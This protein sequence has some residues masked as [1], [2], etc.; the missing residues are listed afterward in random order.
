MEQLRE[1]E[2]QFKQL[3][4]LVS[5]INSNPAKWAA[6]IAS[7]GK[8]VRSLPEP[9]AECDEI[10]V[11]LLIRIFKPQELPNCL[12]SFAER[13]SE[14]P[15]AASFDCQAII[16]MGSYYNPCIIYEEECILDELMSA[17][18]ERSV[19]VHIVAVA[20]A[21]QAKLIERFELACQTGSWLVLQ[22]C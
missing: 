20:R 9:Y 3:K 2:L 11:L 22:N 8:H 12:A 6:Y 14:T 1:A 10:Y 13:L 15:E 18:Q 4:G 16:E 21:Y 19:D 5:D 17:A 7:L